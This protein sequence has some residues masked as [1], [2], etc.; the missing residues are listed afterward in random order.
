MQSHLEVLEVRTS[1][2]EFSRGQR[3]PNLAHIL[4]IYRPL[5]TFCLHPPTSSKDVVTQIFIVIFTSL[6]PSSCVTSRLCI[7]WLLCSGSY[8]ATVKVSAR[9]AISSKAQGFLPA[10]QVAGRIHFP[11]VCLRFL[12]SCYLSARDCSQH[13]E[14]S[15]RSLLYGFFHSKHG[16]LAHL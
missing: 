7:S 1:T 2:Y 9:T 8:Q 10:S 15:L 6:L 12:F 4:P 13:P 14:A 5:Q 3:R 11:V 16:S